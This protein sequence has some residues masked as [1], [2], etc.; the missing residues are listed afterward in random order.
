MQNNL[1]KMLYEKIMCVKVK[2]I[3]YLTF[4]LNIER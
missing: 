4:F 2:N 1:G 3:K